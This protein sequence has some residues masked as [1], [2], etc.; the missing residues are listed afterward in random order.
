MKG[1]APISLHHP[2]INIKVSSLPATGEFHG[3]LRFDTTRNVLFFW[4]Q[5]N[6]LWLSVNQVR[7]QMPPRGGIAMTATATTTDIVYWSNPNRGGNIFIEDIYLPY[8]VGSPL[9]AT[10]NWIFNIQRRSNGNVQNTMASA[11][12]AYT[13]TQSAGTWYNAVWS[14]N[15][16]FN[17]ASAVFLAIQ[18]TKQNN[19]GQIFWEPGVVVWRLVG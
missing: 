3:Q 5:V 14:I 8:L 4:H 2:E 16:S 19:P 10:N 9:D 7:D 15:T 1:D 11:V 18:L 6:N 17:W 13:G 12:N